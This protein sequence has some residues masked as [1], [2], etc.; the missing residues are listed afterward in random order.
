MFYTNA[1]HG[2][3]AGAFV[4]AI[5]GDRPREEEPSNILAG[6]WWQPHQAVYITESVH[7]LRKTCLHSVVE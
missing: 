7:V 1:L 5:C 2:W 4:A 6:S 3:E